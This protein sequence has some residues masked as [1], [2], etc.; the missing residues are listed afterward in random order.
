LTE[1]LVVFVEFKKEILLTE[2]VPIIHTVILQPA[3]NLM[4]SFQIKKSKKRPSALRPQDDKERPNGVI[5]SVSEES[6]F[7]LFLKEE[8]LQSNGFGMTR[9][10]KLTRIFKHPQ[11]LL[12]M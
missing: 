4:L 11:F 9:K 1:K 5:L 2:A 6:H 10:G 12:D 8:I 7:F 3:K